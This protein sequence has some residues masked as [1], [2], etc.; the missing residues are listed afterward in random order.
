[1]GIF[2]K[3]DDNNKEVKTDNKA[4]M[5]DLYGGGS[6]VVKKDSK[7]PTNKKTTVNVAVSSQAYKVLVRP[8]ITEKGSAMNS[9]GKYLFEVGISANKIQIS[10]AIQE[11]Y[12]HKPTSVNVI[13]MPGKKVRRGK[14][15]GKRKDWR[16][17]VVT[18]AKGESLN[19]YEGV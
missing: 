8:L 1:M 10:Q 16:K 7:K 17:A 18:L 9:E 13:N 2:K 12:G 5:K 14:Q 3:N 4:S 11:I 15:V 19:V 6:T